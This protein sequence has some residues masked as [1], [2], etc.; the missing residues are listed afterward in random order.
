MATLAS[1]L[2][3]AVL[4]PTALD[5]RLRDRIG[6]ERNGQ[7]D[8]L[9]DLELFD[10]REDFLRAGFGSLWDYCRRS[11]H[12]REGS[13]HRRIT[14]F[15]TLAALLSHKI[16]NGDLASVLREAVACAVEKHGK[17]RG[18]V[19]PARTRSLV[20]EAAGGETGNPVRAEPDDRE[21]GAKPRRDGSADAAGSSRAIPA[22]VRRQVW[23]RDGGRCTFTGPDGQRCGS[24]HQ[25]ELHHVIAAA[26]GGP[27]T[28]EN[29]TIH[30]KSHNRVEAEEAFGREHMARFRRPRVSGPGRVNSPPPGEVIEAGP[31][32]VIC[33]QRAR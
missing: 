16:P 7:V 33:A 27:S 23:E 4:D 26:L 12:Q 20:P 1:V 22:E 13:T 18:A 30:C 31:E 32:S 5:R 25:V 14:E 8:F 3:P 9:I 6:D 15:E 28:L 21:A 17:R 2:D 11:L 10:R 19:R 24:R 29:L